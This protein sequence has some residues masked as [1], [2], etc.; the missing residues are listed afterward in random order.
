ME[1]LWNLGSEKLLSVRSLRSYCG[2]L[3]NNPE[4]SADAGGLAYR[5]S[6]GNIKGTM[7]GH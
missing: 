7:E 2:N 3:E 5:V 6:K 1:G 4:S